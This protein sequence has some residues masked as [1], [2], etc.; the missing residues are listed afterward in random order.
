MT[1]LKWLPMLVLGGSLALSAHAADPNK[2]L[3]VSISAPETGF[4]PGKVND[5]YSI[6]V[7][8]NI[9]EPLLKYDYLAR[10][11]KIKPNTA[12]ALPEISADGRVYTIRIQPG[13]YFADD[14]VFK[15]KKRELI[16]ADYAYSFR[17]YADPVVNSPVS[18]MMTDWILGLEE[19]GKRASKAGKFDYQAPIP[20]I[21]VLDRYTLKLTL[22][23]PNFIFNYTL[24]A[25]QFG[26]VAREVI[27]AY[28]KD[29]MSHPVGTGPFML[30]EWKQGNKI[31]LVA[32]PN[33]R[34]VVFDG[35]PG[36]NPEDQKIAKALA[37]K[38]LPVVGR[39]EIRVIE[40]EQPRWLSFLNR[41]LD[42]VVL[43]KSAVKTALHTDGEG[44]TTLN[45]ALIKRG[46]QNSHTQAM[47]VTY[48][49]FN[50]QDPVVGGYSKDKIALRRAIALAYP[51]KK[52]V[53]PLLYA[54][55]AIP[56]KGFV[57]Q[58]VPGSSPGFNGQPAYDPALGNALLDEFGYKI[59]ADGYRTLPNGKPLL[60]TQATQASALDKQ[61]NQVWQKTFDSLHIRVQF[62]VA[63]WNEN[64]KS[65][66]AHK[67]QMWS[68]G[69]TASMPDGDDSMVELWSKSIES[70]GNLVAFNRPEFDRAFE[71]SR[72][73][74]N[75]PEREAKFEQMNRIVA[76]YQP[77]I[78][79][80]TRM[81][82]ELTQPYVVGF[83]RHPIY[84]IGGFWRY[85]DVNRR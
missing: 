9:F 13:I 85:V 80:V 46:I 59:G 15:G 37:G 18:N 72:L 74:P 1:H 16:A 4:D 82:N 83:K 51:V 84:S 52:E 43:P 32:N 63:K 14:P 25:K 31:V 5:V 22:N 50:M 28:G 41:Q 64:L 57:T 73:L 40:E 38:T 33:Y 11:L 12:A 19:A 23:K 71:E 42:W 81:Y 77:V 60:I 24:A 48:A 55:Q 79:G 47:D 78:L 30:K 34:K 66:Y 53:V 6:G 67:L 7:I 8:E 76:A 58:G 39:V 2:V 29:T 68:L 62:K 54:N 56:M 17:R 26:A 3:R 10:P 45:P 21:Q 75:G 27:E 20:G 69:G 36:D 49:Y 44:N 70:G 61:F 35:E 65:A